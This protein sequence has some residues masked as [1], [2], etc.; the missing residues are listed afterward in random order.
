MAKLQYMNLTDLTLFKQL[1]DTETLNKI[2]QAVS[3]AIKT[4]SQSAD[5]YTVYFYTKEAPVT[6]DDAAFSI[7]LPNPTDLINA[8]ADKV[9]SAVAGNFA[10]LNASGNLVDSGKKVSD[11]EPVGAANT[12]KTELLKFI[13]TIPTDAVAKTIVAYIRE[14]VE[15]GKYDDAALK[16]LISGNTTAIDMINGTG[17]GSIKK[18]VIDGLNEFTA[19]APD[20]LDT[21]KE[22][23]D[24]ILGHASDAA[25]MN[26]KI[27]ANA[28][29]ISNLTEFV[30][31]LPEGYASKTVI[32]YIAEY[33]AKS[34]TDSD[35]SQYAKAEDLNAAV[36]RIDTAESELRAANLSIAGNTAELGKIKTKL[37]DIPEGAAATTIVGYA[38]ELAD[39]LKTQLS[40][41]AARLTGTEKKVTLLEADLTKAKQDISKN[42]AALDS[43]SDLVGD[44]FEAIPE[45][46]IR[47]LFAAT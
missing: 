17:E 10:G 32:E 35:L 37:G 7:A 20:S 6:E 47:S 40:D 24:W 13:G 19:G 11:F 3:P 26:S 27:N 8:K 36:A 44:G 41:F 4:I 28:A 25:D 18:A 21:Y 14:S 9:K 34:L 31:N 30:G 12:A 33:V 16:A 23:T 46:A 45:S 43:L 2:R 29:N 22:L 15:A 42:A 5:L 38:K 1:S 39:A